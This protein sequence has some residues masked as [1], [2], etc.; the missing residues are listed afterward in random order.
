MTWVLFPT[1]MVHF[2]CFLMPLLWTDM[3]SQ[4]SIPL[5]FIL[6]AVLTSFGVY[7]T[8]SIN[9]CDVNLLSIDSPRRKG[10]NG[11]ERT[12]SNGDSIYC[13]VCEKSVHKSS[14]HCKFCQKCVTAFDHHCKWLNTCIGQANYRFF[15]LA[16]AGITVITSISLAL[17]IAYV[18]ESFSTGDAIEE[19]G[20]KAYIAISL[21]SIKIV[22]I[23]SVVTLLPLV[24]MV[25]QLAGFHVMLIAK[26]LTTYDY[27][28][29]ENKRQ[30]A[31]R[32]AKAQA[33]KE[34]RQQARIKTARA[35][36]MMT[37]GGRDKSSSN[38]KG[39]DEE[40]GGEEGKLNSGGSDMLPRDSTGAPGGLGS[41]RKDDIADAADIEL[42]PIVGPG[43]PDTETM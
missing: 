38:S 12:L 7:A 43:D 28:V 23:I 19:R 20:Q 13:Y 25:Y 29:Q 40:V 3:G 4:V 9:P 15:L 8:C 35:L 41:L 17:S 11:T 22:S 16:V 6:S 1:V 21:L 37:T 33:L 5:L 42:E 30:K 14:K 27:I 32:D 18:V 10:A 31:L 34:Q 26:G 2:F 36:D 24:A 39:D